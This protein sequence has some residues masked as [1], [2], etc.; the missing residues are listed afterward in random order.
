MKLKNQKLLLVVKDGELLELK[1]I[2]EKL[3]SSIVIFERLL[4][5]QRIESIYFEAAK[6]ELENLKNFLLVN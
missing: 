4:K 2:T 6:T 3:E 5:G 1:D